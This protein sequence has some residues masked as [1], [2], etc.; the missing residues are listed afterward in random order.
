M[1]YR[2]A[3]FLQYVGGL[4]PAG[5]VAASFGSYGWSSGAT[6]EVDD[7]LVAIGIEVVQPPFTQKFRPTEVDLEAARAWAAEFAAKVKAAGSAP[8]PGSAADA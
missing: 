8:V 7:R 2:V 4:R 3:G 6:K 1:L 5:R